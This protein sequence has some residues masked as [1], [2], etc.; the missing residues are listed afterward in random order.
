LGSRRQVENPPAGGRIPAKGRAGRLLA[1]FICHWDLDI[2]YFSIIGMVLL[3]PIEDPALTGQ[4]NKEK[5]TK[6]IL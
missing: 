2:G 6:Q 5:T 1:N 3:Y 4:K